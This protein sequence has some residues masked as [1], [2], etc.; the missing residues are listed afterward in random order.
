MPVRPWCPSGWGWWRRV[1][2]RGVQEVGQSGHPGVFGHLPAPAGHG[3]AELDDEAAACAASRCWRDP[4][5]HRSILSH[6]PGP[7]RGAFRRTSPQQGTTTRAR[8]TARGVE[9]SRCR[10]RCRPA[11]RDEE[12]CAHPGRSGSQGWEDAFRT[13][14]VR[15]GIEHGD[16]QRHPGGGPEAGRP[17]VVG[18]QD[19]ELLRPP[20]DAAGSGQT[21]AARVICRL[22]HVSG[23]GPGGRRR[24]GGSLPRTRSPCRKR[25]EPAA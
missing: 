11:F 7:W 14:R 4:D 1:R 2:C 20:D 13:C 18:D 8:D 16:P 25:S 5:D 17:G 3:V 24:S 12:G 19:V 23:R 21:T 10:A 6:V 9:G 15:C 22:S